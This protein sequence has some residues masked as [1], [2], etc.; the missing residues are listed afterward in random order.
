MGNK[1]LK[2]IIEIGAFIIVLMLAM[3]L[4]ISHVLVPSEVRTVLSEANRKANGIVSDSDINQLITLASEAVVFRKAMFLV[5]I[6]SVA[7]VIVVWAFRKKDHKGNINKNSMQ[8][9]LILLIL[10]VF[11]GFY[12]ESVVTK[13]SLALGTRDQLATTVLLHG[14]SELLYLQ[15]K[16]FAEKNKL[17]RSKSDEDE[18]KKNSLFFRKMIPRSYMID[19]YEAQQK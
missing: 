17:F 12:F 7:I 2:F 1:I 3:Q 19:F 11:I 8:E 14:Q 16:K 5:G 6:M 9:T 18:Y 13:E 4:Y 10:I 15:Y